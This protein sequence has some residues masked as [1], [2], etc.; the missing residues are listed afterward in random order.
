MNRKSPHILIL[1]IDTNVIHITCQVQIVS[2]KK[3]I[4][5][6]H[7][8]TLHTGYKEITELR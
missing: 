1:M 4:G 7:Y 5:T 8:G 2:R 3:S 6:D